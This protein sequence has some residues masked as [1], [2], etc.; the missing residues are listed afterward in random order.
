MIDPVLFQKLS[1][2]AI[3]LLSKLISIPSFSREESRTADFIF[4]FLQDRGVRA[5][6]C[7]NNVYAFHAP[8]DPSKPTL[9]LNSHHD[10]VRPNAAYARDPFAAEIS[11]GR[12]YGLGSNDAGGALVSMISVF[13]FYH[14]RKDLPYNLCLAATAEEEVSGSGGMEYFRAHLSQSTGFGQNPMD[15]AIIGEPTEMKMAVAEKGLLVVDAV[16]RGI[17]GH[18]AHDRGENAIYKAM[19]DIDWI[20]QYAFSRS[21]PF[22]G[23][24]RWSVTSI[25][26]ENKAHNVIPDT[27]HFT[28]DI[29]VNELYAFEEI[30]EILRRNTS[31]EFAPRSLRL[32]STLIPLNHP[33]VQAG[34]KLGR[35]CYGSPTTSDKALVGVPALKMGPGDSNRSHTADE[36][37]HLQEIK[38]GIETYI[39]LLE[40]LFTDHSSN[41]NPGRT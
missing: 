10:T 2:E 30:L 32:R 33:L 39:H 19:E 38:D 16:S 18:A 5:E 21:S 8:F 40:R 26:T 34:M 15:C 35:E 25:H 29:R 28:L 9:L 36:Y 14:G 20:R 12:L 22:L 17:A 4:K 24:V 7:L 23:N 11:D 6:R 37:I 41:Q 13:L 31:S 3:Q 1:E 27:C